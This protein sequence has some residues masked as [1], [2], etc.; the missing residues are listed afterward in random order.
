MIVSEI[1][2]QNANFYFT[3]FS[4]LFYCRL[5]VRIRVILQSH[6]YTSVTSDDM[7]TVMVTSHEIIEKDIE[8]SRRI[9]LYNVYNIY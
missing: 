9:K 3:F 5:K 2:N 1:Q 7:V 8:G 6:C 4:N